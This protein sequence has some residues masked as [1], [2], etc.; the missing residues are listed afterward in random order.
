MQTKKEN[1]ITLYY[2]ANNDDRGINTY[3]CGKNKMT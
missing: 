1:H 3:Y 2:A